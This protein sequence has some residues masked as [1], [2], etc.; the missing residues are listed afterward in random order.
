M[1][2]RAS[3]EPKKTCQLLSYCEE[4]EYRKVK[5]FCK[6]SGISMSEFLRNAAI[7]KLEAA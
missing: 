1:A 5:D 7:E 3:S 4:A 2:K 6:S